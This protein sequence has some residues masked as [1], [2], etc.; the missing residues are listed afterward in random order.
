MMT[1][2][3]TIA[4]RG[5]FT[6]LEVMLSLTILSLVVAGISQ[7]M[8][9][10]EG[11]GQAAEAR[12]NVNQAANRGLRR[13]LADLKQTG[14]TNDGGTN[15]PV[16]FTDGDPGNEFP[17]LVHAPPPEGCREIIFLLPADVDG[18]KIPD[19][20]ANRNIVWDAPVY[21]FRLVTSPDGVNR[22]QRSV[23]GAGFRNIVSHVESVVFDDAIS[24]GF[25][26]P[27]DA[28]RVQLTLAQADHHGQM[29]R[30]TVEGVV[31]ATNGG[32]VIP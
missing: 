12:A 5:G 6:A 14:F 9:S 2:V 10:M 23:D 16:L 24:S 15:F 28:L 26:I 4:A 1:R 22:L 13:I 18:N 7:A 11:L 31:R 21:S 27:L 8:R 29:H 19:L 17:G 20:D 3:R 25:E 30:I 32:N